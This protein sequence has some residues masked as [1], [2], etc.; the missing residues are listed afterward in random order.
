MTNPFKFGSVVDEPFFTDREEEMKRIISFFGSENH[1]TLISPRRF[2]KTSLVKRAVRVAG[3][4]HIYLDM[5]VIVSPEDIAAQLLRRIYNL[6]AFE[7]LKGLIRNFRII[8]ALRLNPVTGE[9]DVTFNPGTDG[10]TVLEDVLNL[11]D[12]LG[13]PKRKIVVIFDEFQEIFRIGQGL[14]R[15]MRSVM[16]G[17]TNVN[18]I[19]LGSSESMIREVFE[20]KKSP[21]Y[22]FAALMTLGPLPVIEFS[23]YLEERFADVVENA[24]LLTAGILSVTGAHPYYTQQLAFYVWERTAGSGFNV[25]IVDEAISEIIKSHDYDYERL[26]N[27]LNRTDMK[28]MIGMANG[29]AEPLSGSFINTTGLGSTSTV[30][31]ALKRLTTRGLLIKQGT[32]YLYDDP[33]F[34]R[35]ILERRSS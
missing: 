21:F 10:H 27:S 14:D 31:S 26:W 32:E 24:P 2:G 28:V 3:S 23:N 15:I 17:H 11:L 4:K 8:P 18:Y 22:H 12:S 16:Q 30:Y 9:I 25:N 7:K 19:F 5:Q 13:S 29:E 35:W 6:S 34:R 20:S 1:L 33:F